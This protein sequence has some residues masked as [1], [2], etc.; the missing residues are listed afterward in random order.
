MF[1]YQIARNPFSLTKIIAGLSKTLKIA[2][3]VIPLYGQV[4]PMI[5]NARQAF[6]LL[7]PSPKPKQK[8]VNII[9]TSTPRFFI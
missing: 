1:P 6:S 3:Q 2:N 8:E 4:K 7:K 9:P 5:T